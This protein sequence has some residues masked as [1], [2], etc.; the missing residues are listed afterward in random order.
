MVFS[1]AEGSFWRN[2]RRGVVGAWSREG[3]CSGVE[4]CPDVDLQG[5]GLCSCSLKKL[6]VHRCLRI[7][8][9]SRFRPLNIRAAG[10]GFMLW[11]RGTETRKASGASG[12]V[13][14]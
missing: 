8:E 9:S 7:D 3:R 10:I 13:G 1:K 4:A 14:T 11:Q 2:G 5:S 12:G 6:S